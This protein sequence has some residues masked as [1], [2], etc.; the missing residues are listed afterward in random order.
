MLPGQWGEGQSV[1]NKGTVVGSVFLGESSQAALWADGKKRFI[2]RDQ[3]SSHAHCIDNHGRVYGEH[4]RQGSTWE[5]FVRQPGGAVEYLDILAN[6]SSFIHAVNN[7]GQIAVSFLRRSGKETHAV[8]ALY[9]KGRVRELPPT[10]QEMRCRANSINEKG[11]IVGA[12]WL[13]TKPLVQPVIWKNGSPH[14]LETPKDATGIATVINDKGDVAGSLN[15]RK[16]LLLNK[17]FVILNGRFSY[18]EDLVKAPNINMVSVCSLDNEGTMVVSGLIDQVCH[19]F[20]LTVDKRA[21]SF[22]PIA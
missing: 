17:A 13:T 21:V 7:R 20:L 4:V 1:D 12:Q 5:C 16:D 22:P 10:Q 14:V 3:S 8:A 15:T 19:A 6:S 11:T 18:L 9:D 2:F